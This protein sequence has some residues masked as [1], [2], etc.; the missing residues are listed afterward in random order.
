MKS[1]EDDERM[2]HA[3]HASRF[4]WGEALE[5]KP[6]NL[7]RGERQISRVYTVVGLAEPALRHAQ[8]CLALCEAN[9]LGDWDL[10]YAYEAI[11]RAYKTAGKEPEAQAYKELAAETP[12]IEDDDREH[13][14]QDLDTL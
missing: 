10:A 13:L 2:I 5:C 6:E 14:E 7:A 8:R 9:G 12:V 3:A 1:R 11:A 4:H